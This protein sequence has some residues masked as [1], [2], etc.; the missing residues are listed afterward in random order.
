MEQEQRYCDPAVQS[1]TGKRPPTT[2]YKLIDQTIS[3]GGWTDKPRARQQCVGAID[4]ML[5]FAVAHEGLSDDWIITQ[6]QKLTL[7]GNGKP[8][9]EKP[10][11]ILSDFQILELIDS[12]I[13]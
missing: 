11:A 10:T 13:A 12:A 2:P 5:T 7:A 8:E 1:L 6:Y 3:A 9:E 4:R